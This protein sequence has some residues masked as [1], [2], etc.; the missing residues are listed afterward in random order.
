MTMGKHSTADRPFDL[1]IARYKEILTLAKRKGYG[2]YTVQ[3]F[4]DAG[5]PTAAALVLRHDLD[6]KPASLWPMLEAERQCGVRSTVY[7]RVAADEY[8]LLGYHVLP[9][10][11]AAQHDGFEIGLHT[12]CVEFAAINRL[13]PLKLIRSETR[14]LREFFT[15]T[16]VAA[17]RDF[18]FIH[19][20][21]PWIRD[22]WG[23]LD[24]DFK[25]EAYDKRIEDS[26]VYVNDSFASHL[27]WK[28]TPYEALDTGKSIYFSAHSHWWYVDHPFEV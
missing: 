7:V 24:C 17:H 9:K 12:N 23:S 20:S 18:N 26:T 8:N 25:Y 5:F 4:I 10:L 1:S 21:L 27:H 28:V 22:N 6:L 19:N 2:F 11:L 16:G 3:E 14:I 13:D 15:V